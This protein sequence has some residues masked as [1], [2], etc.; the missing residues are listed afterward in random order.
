MRRIL[1]ALLALIVLA[2]AFIGWRGF[3]RGERIFQVEEDNNNWY[4]ECTYQQFGGKIRTYSG[5]WATRERAEA[6]A[7]CPFIRR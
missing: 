2:G 1:L 5:G 7:W 3:L 4:V 6:D